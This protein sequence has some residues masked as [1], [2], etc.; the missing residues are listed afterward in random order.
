MAKVKYTKEI[1][2]FWKN[3]NFNNIT[4]GKK[5]WPEGWDARPILKDIIKNDTIIEMGCGYGRLVKA[6]TPEQ[7]TGYDINPHAVEEAKRKNPQYSFYTYHIGDELPES[8]WIMFYTV[9]LHINDEDIKDYLK[10]VTKNTKKVL[11]SEILGRA[12][13]GNVWNYAFNRDLKHYDEIF[14]ELGFKKID[15]FEKPYH[16]YKDT[17]ISFISYEQVK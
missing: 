14:E 4:A 15:Y 1:L 9:L 5:E 8:D 2:D 11:I 3:D 16:H 10:V 13:W 17:N 7:Y 12:R 6:F